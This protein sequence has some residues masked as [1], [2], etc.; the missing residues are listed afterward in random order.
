MKNAPAEFLALDMLQTA[1]MVLNERMHIVYINPSLEHLFDLSSTEL[2]HQ[3]LEQV[4]PGASCLRHAFKTVRLQNTSFTEHDIIW[5]QL[6]HEGL[7]VTCTVSALEAPLSGML[8][9]MRPLDKQLKIASDERHLLQ[10][11]ANRELLRNFAH[12]IKNPL[13]G[14]RGAAQLLEYEL[15]RP[16]LKEYTEVIRHEADRLQSLMDRLLTPHKIPQPSEL[17]MH[18]VLERVR[19]L[20]LAENQKQALRIQR[21][22]DTSLPDIYGDKEQLIQVVLNIVRNAVQ[23]MHGQGTIVL[24][25]RCAR[26]VTLARHRQTL[27]LLLQ[28]ID[29][30]P[31]IPEAIKDTLF[32]PLVTGRPDGSGLGLTIAQTY[33]HQHFGSI[34]V[35]SVPGRTCFSILLPFQPPGPNHAQHSRK[36][37]P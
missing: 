12:E 33:V 4:L 18:E 26:Q 10:Q 16:E 31:G 8:V 13:G 30:G 5:P 3:P 29:N 2:L 22:Y 15:E 6:A 19:S 24:K 11:Q 7:H 25:T 28:I 35:D 14:I 34:E 9:E 37:L 36:D 17:N 21:D 20:V 23:A 32:Y 27:A 1:V